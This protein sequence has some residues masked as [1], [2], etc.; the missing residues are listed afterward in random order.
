MHV[1]YKV[2][3]KGYVIDHQMNK[4]RVKGIEWQWFEYCMH[5]YV[6]SNCTASKQQSLCLCLLYMLC[7]CCVFSKKK[8]QTFVLIIYNKAYNMYG[9]SQCIEDI[10]NDC[11]SRI[12]C[13]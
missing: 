8:N 9:K 5:F 1:W 13:F 6:Y 3:L 7:M 11:L 12:L 10:A 4:I 2:S